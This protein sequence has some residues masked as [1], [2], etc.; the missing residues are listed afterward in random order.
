M[1]KLE[2]DISE[3]DALELICLVIDCPIYLSAPI[4]KEYNDAITARVT[5]LNAE[6]DNA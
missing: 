1:I 4:Y 2:K 5:I 6:R 3:M